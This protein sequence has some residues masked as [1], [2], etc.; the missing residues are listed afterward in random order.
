VPVARGMRTSAAVAATT[1][2]AVIVLVLT[3][4]PAPAG[5][6]PR[7][8]PCSSYPV[9]GT[10]APRAAKVSAALTARYAI[11]RRRQRRVDRLR[12]DQI[13][14]A[15]GATGLIMSGT[16][17]LGRAAY[18]GRI[19][20]IPAEHVLVFRLAPLR[21]VPPDQR[22]LEQTL[23]PVLRSEY[24]HR[25]MCIEVIGGNGSS[26]ICTAASSAP[27]A[28]LYIAGTPGFGLVPNGVSSVTVTYQTA[29][30]RTVAVRHN[31]FIIVS[32][33]HTAAPCGVQW[34]ESGG[35]V[36]K[37]PTGCSYLA[38]ETNELDRYRIYVAGELS[39]LNSQVD[40]L[41]SAIAS[42]SAADA[43]SAWLTAH[44]TWLDIGQD[45]GAY[46]CFG[47]LGGDIDGLAAGHPLGTSDP[48]FTGF[49][50][51]EFDLWTNHDLAAAAADTATLQRLLARLESARISS[52]L[53]ANPTGIG[54]WLLRPHEVLEDAIRDTLSG[55]DDYGSGTGLAS[56][57]ADAAAV[58]VMLTEIAPQLD[59]LAPGLRR[60]AGGQL[61]ALISAVDAT[62]V[63]GAWV[64]IDELAAT[65]RQQIDADADAAAETLAPI[66]D[67]MTS[68]GHNAPAS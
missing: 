15:L 60:R 16:R 51:I 27:D 24:R 5:A 28:L 36:I 48:G 59:P 63:N 17:F 67:L 44:L 2:V 32:P 4:L 56:L 25:A 33:S 30:P 1:L 6:R 29:P 55:D 21:C 22:G 7:A 61:D 10:L 18:G 39:T 41:A 3:G 26:P 53:P 35:T 9:P 66:P 57:S 45:D 19:Y 68:T 14:P 49:H 50:R 65:Q 40:A 12:P 46:G 58:R 43:E 37:V 31:F 13:D 52:Y 20:L 11:L 23:R 62:R 47:Q 34:L 64:A 54:N 8:R 38:A 42:R